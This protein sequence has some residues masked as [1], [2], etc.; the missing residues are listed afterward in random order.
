MLLFEAVD[1]DQMRAIRLACRPTDPGR[2]AYHSIFYYRTSDERDTTKTILA[3]LTENLQELYARTAT[4][5]EVW[6]L[7]EAACASYRDQIALHHPKETPVPEDFMRCVPDPII[8]KLIASFDALAT[9]L[10]DLRGG[11]ANSIF[12]GRA[13]SFADETVFNLKLL[14]KDQEK[15]VRFEP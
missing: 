6:P 12:L 3:A 10:R 15:H 13:I 1:D 5:D 2:N 9:E 14:K 11:G 7:L 4:D 8:D